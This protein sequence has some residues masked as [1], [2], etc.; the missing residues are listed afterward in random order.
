MADWRLLAKK[1][2]LADGKIDTREARI[3]KDA[4]LA[5][6]KIDK[7][8]FEFLIE[9]RR[10]A[11][12]V[13]ADYDNLV[14]AAIKPVILKDGYISVD[15]TKWLKKLFMSDG[16]IDDREK[17]FLKELKDASSKHCKDYVD[18]CASLGI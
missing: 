6:G 12:S 11:Q 14:F 5:D 2:A 1:L 16:K 4:L 13:V 9:L 7:T 18:W 15:E 17:K 8:E 10:G 3:I